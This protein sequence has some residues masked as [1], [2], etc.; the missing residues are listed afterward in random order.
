MHEELRRRGQMI[1]LNY[2]QAHEKIES[3]GN[4]VPG[5]E[6][7]GTPEPAEGRRPP[8]TPPATP[9]RPERSRQKRKSKL[10]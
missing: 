8:A 3:M 10:E 9:E 2:L 7:S 4:T 5:G 6:Q 1:S